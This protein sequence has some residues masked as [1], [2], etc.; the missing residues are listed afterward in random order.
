MTRALQLEGAV[1]GRLVVLR[2][3]GSVTNRNGKKKAAWECLCSPEHGG[4]GATKI[5]DS[6][7]LV[8]DTRSCGCLALDVARARLTTHGHN[9]K[10]GSSPTYKSWSSMLKRCTDPNAG[11]FRY[12]GGRGIEVCA[13]WRTFENFLADMGERPRGTSIDRIDNNGNYEPGNCRW[14]TARQQARNSRKAHEIECGGERLCL[15]EWQERTGVHAATIRSRL[16]RG[17]SVESALA[18]LGQAKPGEGKRWKGGPLP[19]RR[20]RAA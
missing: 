2:R 10:S 4:C 1:F 12:Y 5:V 7:S 20:R 11:S 18:P 8:R 9:P 17:M 19:S 6:A 16:K 14:A 15:T 13:R 3:A